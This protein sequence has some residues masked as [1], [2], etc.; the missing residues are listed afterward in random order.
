[1]SRRYGRNQ[2]RRH[3]E[4]IARLNQ[5]Y[6]MS[7]G[8]SRRN[9]E[10]LKEANE[11]MAKMIRTIEKVCCHS[12]AIPPKEVKGN[13]LRDHFR[14]DVRRVCNLG[15]TSDLRR[16]STAETFR[17]IDLYALQV[18]LMK[19]Q[20]K[21]STAVHLKYSGGGH[22]AYM[23]S[24]YALRSMSHDDLMRHF[25]PEIADAMIRNLREGRQQGR[26]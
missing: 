6:A 16:M 20:D 26:R 17:V 21:F 14:I 19:H 22:T 10:N 13:E 9:A 11:T 4:E 24:E 25:V 3:R 23:I 2:K 1:M 18:Y 8:L 15:P 7:T 12:I 5:A